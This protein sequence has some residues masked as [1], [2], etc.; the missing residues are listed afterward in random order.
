M[1]NTRPLRAEAGHT[2]PD[3]QSTYNSNS[4]MQDLPGVRN[5]GLKTTPT[6]MKIWGQ[7]WESW[8][9]RGRDLRGHE[10]KESLALSRFGWETHV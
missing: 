1:L 9:G 4:Q 3:S 5:L 2:M 8:E 6:F 7:E 10:L